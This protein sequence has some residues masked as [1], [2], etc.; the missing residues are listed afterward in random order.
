MTEYDKGT[1]RAW[2]REALRGVVN[3]IIPTFTAD[4]SDVNEAATRH[5]VRRDIELGFLGALLVAET[6]TSRDEYIRFTRWAA[7]EAQGRLQLWHHASFNTLDEN[8]EMVRRAGKAGAEMVLLS[9]PATFYPCAEEE[10]FEYTKR[11]C[12]ATDLAVMLFQVPLWGFERIHP[13]G[14]SVQL[15]ERI[16]DAC[17]N[18]VAIKAEGGYPSMIGFTEV[19]YRLGERVVVSQPIEQ[20]A[21][22]FA[23]VLPLQ[24]IATSNTECLGPAVPEMLRLI[25]AGKVD[26]AMELFWRV[27]PARKANDVVTAIGGANTVHRMAWK[28][29]AWLTGF[30]GGPLRMPT[31]RLVGSQMAAFRKAAVEAGVCVT[32]APDQEFFRGRN[33]A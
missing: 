14:M 4:L 5:D 24:L 20:H 25:H 3:V 7:D 22:P 31:Q 30:N 33:P 15:L 16:V 26:D 8:I 29:Q 17:P 13:A 11:F 19:W 1:A 23:S 28:Y 6:A 21:I 2:A 9:Y 10:I 12:D 18:V 32:D 27:H